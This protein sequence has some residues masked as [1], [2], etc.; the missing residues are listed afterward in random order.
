MQLRS[1]DHVTS[2]DGKWTIPLLMDQMPGVAETQTH[3]MFTAKPFGIAEF[4]DGMKI[5]I[6]DNLGTIPATF[7]SPSMTDQVAAFFTFTILDRDKQTSLY[8]LQ[9][10]DNQLEAVALNSYQ[11]ALQTLMTPP[12]PFPTPLASPESVVVDT[13]T[14]STTVTIITDT[15]NLQDV[16]KEFSDDY[17]KE[18]ERLK[19]GN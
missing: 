18:V 5:Q 17:Q 16:L 4:D 8:L 9:K 7:G 13:P 2:V 12:T 19:N 11:T 6:G 1:S 14:L 3:Q 15:Q 10:Q